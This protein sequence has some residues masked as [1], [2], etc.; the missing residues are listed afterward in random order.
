[1]RRILAHSRILYSLLAVMLA[2][3]LLPLAI[4]S[5][6]LI[7]INR[8]SLLAAQ[9]SVQIDEAKGNALAVEAFVDGYAR[10]TAAVARALELSGGL[11]VDVD[12][13]ARLGELL[14]DDSNLVA[15]AVVEPGGPPVVARGT[16]QLP[17]S[18]LAKLVAEGSS[19]ASAGGSYVGQ[20]Q[21]AGD[22]GVPL[23]AM[24]HPIPI[25]GGRAGAVVSIV[26]M[27]AAFPFLN[28]VPRRDHGGE[29]V[30][31]NPSGSFVVDDHGTV[32]A[33]SR[34][35][36]PAADGV[37]ALVDDWLAHPDESG[38]LTREFGATVDG[39]S[40]RL[41][42]SVATAELGGGRR[43]GIGSV[44]SRDVAMAHAN[45]MTAQTVWAGLVVAFV[46]ALIAILFAGYIANPIKELATG[47]R[48]MADGDFS[49]RIHVWSNNETG[50][51]AEDFNRM[52]ERLNS[53]VEEMRDAAVRNHEL[54]I[55]TVRGLAAAIDGKDPYTRG[56]SERVAEFSSA[57]AI[58]LG[59]PEDEV[60]KIRISGLMHDV[61]KLAIEDKILRKPAALTD[62]EF[63]IM[64]E[65][66]ERGARIMSEIPHMR[67]YI[68]GMRFHH[69]MMNGK[70]YPL[71]L[72]GDQIPL[73]AKIV[74]VADSFDAMTTNR[75]YQKQ[76]PIDLVFEKIREMA[77][78]RY[79]P[80]VVEALVR[81]YDNGRIRL[82]MK[83]S[84]A[85]LS[86]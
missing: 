8:T 19:G 26:D 67:E 46:T 44:V 78:I 33:S 76:M 81:A 52:A 18:E 84:G 24:S 13:A 71:G 79:D 32:L 23:I 55:G 83:K 61:G 9:R 30:A 70:G 31:P 4:V 60:E 6:R 10:Q 51:L 5:W 27:T 43:I 21:R 35:G 65:H 69:E 59:L 57:M 36:A 58:E 39:Q 86:Q 74:S 72:E 42:G 53:T 47:A 2:M 22:A 17:E 14:R 48:A 15:I 40:A 37:S 11:R 49:R 62:E 20:P 28:A 80:D 64:R 54:F 3:A 16:A 77:G 82:R 45:R 50:Q 66:P 63:E 85:G 75:P 73:M 29:A 68:P 25:E 34:A 1:M 12:L 38:G 7:S 56:H 41:L